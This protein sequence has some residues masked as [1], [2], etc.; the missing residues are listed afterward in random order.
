VVAERQRFGAAVGEFTDELN[1]LLNATIT[2]QRLIFTVL[3]G[4]GVSTGVIS[5]RRHGSPIPA[6]LPTRF[7]M[8]G[9]Y[10]GQFCRVRSSEQSSGPILFTLKYKYSLHK[11]PEPESDAI[12]RWEYDRR[13]TD[14]NARWCRRHI[15]GPLE[16][17][18][19][20]QS[21]SMNSLHFPSGYVALE[22]IIRFCIHDLGVKPLNSDW[23]SILIDS[24]KAFRAK[25]GQ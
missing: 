16:L 19:G 5:F 13:P 17:L 23:D 25:F 4:E 20:G 18:L 8:M 2:Q 14:P 15:Q 21:V 22:D 24:Y 9:L 11:D 10:L 3:P 7:G 1:T 6:P 12:I